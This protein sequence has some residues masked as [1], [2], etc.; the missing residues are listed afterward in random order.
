M[1]NNKVVE[2]KKPTMAEDAV[3]E[4][5]SGRI[6]MQRVT[7]WMFLDGSAAIL[8]DGMLVVATAEDV[9][10]KAEEEKALAE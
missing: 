1:S 10:Q 7:F 3:R 2:L 6:G 9:A 5:P 4:Y 8:K